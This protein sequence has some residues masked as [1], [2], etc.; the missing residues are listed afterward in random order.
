MGLTHLTFDRERCRAALADGA[1][2]A[3]DVAEA[4]ALTGIPF[5]TAYKL[6]GS[7]VRKCADLGIALSKVPLEVARQVDPRFTAEILSAADAA[8]AVARKRNQ[9]GPGP[10]SIAEQISYFRSQGQA[11]QVTAT[12]TPRLEQIFEKLKEAPL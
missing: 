9:G 5:R 8:E 3:T 10:A 11:A 2:A 1:T 7:L 12:D 4:L 6:T